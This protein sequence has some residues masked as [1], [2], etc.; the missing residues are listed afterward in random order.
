ML[1]ATFS[2]GR[3]FSGETVGQVVKRVHPVQRY[4]LRRRLRLLLHSA[5]S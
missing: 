1:R 3:R 2:V 5:V 4:R